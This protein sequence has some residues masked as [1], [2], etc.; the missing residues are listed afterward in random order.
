[1]VAV[2]SGNWDF[3]SEIDGGIMKR[4]ANSNQ[5]ERKIL[6]D[7]QLPSFIFIMPMNMVV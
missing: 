1:M 2:V 4:L 6:F 5:R 7:H 3:I